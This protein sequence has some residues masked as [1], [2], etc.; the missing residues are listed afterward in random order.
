MLLYFSESLDWTLKS[1]RKK[2]WKTQC[3]E[4]SARIRNLKSNPETCQYGTSVG[5]KKS[6]QYSY[7]K[8][9]VALA[10]I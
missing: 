4:I 6:F 10:C 5:G 9:L 8:A 7:K 3:S 2:N 1:F